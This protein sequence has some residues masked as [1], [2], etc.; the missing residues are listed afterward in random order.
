MKFKRFYRIKT[1]E[2]KK[3]W[4]MPYYTTLGKVFKAGRIKLFKL[5][6]FHNHKIMDVHF[7]AE[8]RNF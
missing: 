7:N 4:R 2:I 1:I 8:Q 3:S 6:P 5:F